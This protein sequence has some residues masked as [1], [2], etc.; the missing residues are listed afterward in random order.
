MAPKEKKRIV[1]H[2]EIEMQVLGI[3]HSDGVVPRQGYIHI[4]DIL[5]MAQELGISERKTK[6]AISYLH[7]RGFMETMPGD[8]D[9]Y[10]VTPAGE[11]HLAGLIGESAIDE[12]L[13]KK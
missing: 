10:R 5:K 13:A 9:E 8:F 7:S 1:D 6:E 4:W 11:E 12:A 3:A 2:K